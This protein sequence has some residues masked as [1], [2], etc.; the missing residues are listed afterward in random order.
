MSYNDGSTAITY[1]E[2][3]TAADEVNGCAKT[4]ESIFDDFIK[5]MNDVVADDVFEGSASESLFEK[6]AALK[7][8]LHTYTETVQE[9]SSIIS[10]AT[11]QTEQ[12]EKDILTDVEEI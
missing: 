6:F 3:R 11:D 12:T 1:E 8:R 5:A 9:F 10:S 7:S 2:V 4:M